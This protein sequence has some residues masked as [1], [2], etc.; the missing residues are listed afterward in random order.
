MSRFLTFTLAICQ[1]TL[2]AMEAHAMGGNHP[3][4]KFVAGTKKDWPQGLSELINTGDRVGG[5]WVNQGDFFFYRGDAA[6]LKP[7]LEA[8]GKLPNSPLVVM[9]HVGT[10]PMTGP[11][12]GEQKTPIRLAT[13]N[14]AT[15]L[16]RT[17]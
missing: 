8:Y 17:H 1:F 3:P 9:L 4:G 13:R 10:R 6:A 12:G 7:F 2:F 14:C 5:Y 16:G 15:R 11:L